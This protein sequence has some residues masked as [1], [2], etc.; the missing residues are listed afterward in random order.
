MYLVPESLPNEGEITVLIVGDDPSIMSDAEDVLHEKFP[1][2]DIR[3]MFSSFSVA[4]PTSSDAL[5]AQLGSY[6]PDVIAFSVKHRE[7]DCMFAVAKLARKTGRTITMLLRSTDARCRGWIQ[8]RIDGLIPGEGTADDL[9]NAL[10]KV[11]R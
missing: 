8:M 6:E 5:V 7:A 11:V 2:A 1:S 9:K 3:P 4:G 10:R